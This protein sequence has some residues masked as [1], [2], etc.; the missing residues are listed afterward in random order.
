MLPILTTIPLLASII[1]GLLGKT[2]TVIAE[3]VTMTSTTAAFVVSGYFAWQVALQGKISFGDY[4]ALDAISALVL[5]IIA[6]VGMN[7]ALYSAGYLNEEM[8]KGIIGPSRVWQYHVL[9]NAFLFAMFLAVT[10]TNPII[11]WVSIEATTLTTAF[12]VSFYN[13]PSAL[14]AALKYVIVNSVGLLIG[15]FGVVI[16]LSAA[17]RGMGNVLLDWDSLRTYALGIDP[18]TAKI[19]FIFILVGFGTKV[20]LVPMH[21]WLPDAHSKAP[22][23]ISALLS[24]VLLNV[25]FLA[26]LRFKSIIDITLGVTF[27]SNLLLFF[28]LASVFLVAFTIISQ[29]HYKRLLAYSSV[30]NMGVAAV[31]VGLGGLA[32]YGAALHLLFH[33]LAK[34]LL[35]LSSGSIF[36][37]YHSTH[38]AKVRGVFRVMPLTGTFFF[39]GVLTVVGMPP[40]AIFTSK[41]AILTQAM[42]VRPYVAGLLL[43]LFGLIFVGFMRHASMMLFGNPP[44]GIEEGELKSQTVIP[45]AVLMF[46]IVYLSFFMPAPLLHLIKQAALFIDPH[47]IF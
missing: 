17:A 41:L 14:E 16:L 45:L 37:K 27:A 6:F 3:Y 12:L 8:R 1:V 36:V 32:A 30:E 2:K 13:K 5:L 7:V 19:A 42:M 38:I 20:G 22:A 25:A 28:G 43:F 35:F 39:L 15:F 9:L 24:G 47:A 34:S 46:T 40:F 31:G 21:T 11:M 44:E 10:T 23:P 33:S 18:L 26:I 29:G 4:F